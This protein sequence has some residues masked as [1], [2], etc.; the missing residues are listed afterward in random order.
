IRLL[1]NELNVEE[2]VKDRSF[3]AFHDRCRLFYSPPE[4]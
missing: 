1:R 2:V 3:K 4:V